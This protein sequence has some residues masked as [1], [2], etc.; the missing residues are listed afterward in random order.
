[1]THVRK[2]VKYLQKLSHKNA[3]LNRQNNFSFCVTIPPQPKPGI[4]PRSK[5]NRE[6]FFVQ[7]IPN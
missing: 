1:M 2:S 6:D 5:F 7:K 3:I 4:R